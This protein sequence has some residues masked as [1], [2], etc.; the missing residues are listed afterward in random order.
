MNARLLN[1]ELAGYVRMGQV[2][3]G[4]S[5][6]PVVTV[7]PVT[8]AEGFQGRWEASRRACRLVRLPLPALRYT[9]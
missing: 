2:P 7:P 4:D 1:A 8:G 6:R 9:P 3:E 5:G